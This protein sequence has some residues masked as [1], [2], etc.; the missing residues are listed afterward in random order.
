M[1]QSVEASL[2]AIDEAQL[3][4]ALELARQSREH[5]NHPFGSVVADAAGSIVAE[6]ENTVVTEGDVLGHAEA[7]A[8][9]L[10]AAR[11]PRPT[12]ATYT[13]YTT[14]EPCAMCAGAIYWANIGRVVYAL[15]EL[16]LLAMTGSDPKNPTLSLPCRD[17]FARG[18][19]TVR[20]VGPVPWPEAVA[21]HD[22][23]WEPPGGASRP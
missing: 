21:V 10:A 16:E 8:A 6:A 14:A 23:F 5:G 19:R 17:V 2:T 11:I 1:E 7:N 12:L 15:S 4:R 9:R 18:Q 22:G 3:R 20:V 13:L